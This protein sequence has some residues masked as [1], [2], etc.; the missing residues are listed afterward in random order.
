MQRVEPVELVER[1][2]DDLTDPASER[3]AQLVEALVVAVHDAGARRHSRC[4]R[5]VQLAAGRDVEEHA[6][7]VGEAGHRLAQERLGGV[8]RP[9]RSERR[10]RLAAAG[11]QVG[12][13]VDEHRRTELG[14]ELVDATAADRQRAVVG[15]RRVVRQQPPIEHGHAIR[16]SGA[17]V[18]HGATSARG[19]R[20]RAG[21]GR[22]T[23]SRPW[24]RKG[25]AGCAAWLV[26][27]LQHR[28][29]LVE[30]G[31]VG[32]QVVEVGAEPVRAVAV[33]ASPTRRRRTR[34]A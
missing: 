7:L 20:C 24:S 31:E 5:H 9:A 15:D 25:R 18:G 19:R 27:G 30:R 11:A 22:G 12:L 33:E 14:D 16:T 21:R 23:G 3:Q 8:D 26:V 32:R 29:V 34:A 2:D 1:V 28:A 6:L 17:G 4:Q 10:H 13:V